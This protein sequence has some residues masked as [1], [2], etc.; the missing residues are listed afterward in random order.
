MDIIQKV[1]SGEFVLA[2]RRAFQRWFGVKPSPTADLDEARFKYQ[3]KYESIHHADDLLALQDL[4]TTRLIG[5]D[6]DG[7]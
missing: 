1:R 3:T 2:R 7:I 5:M 6:K 4:M